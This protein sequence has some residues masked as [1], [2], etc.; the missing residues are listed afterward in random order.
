MDEKFWQ[1]I[2]GEFEVSTEKYEEDPYLLEE[3]THDLS[4]SMVDILEWA[5]KAGYK[6]AKGK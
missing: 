2:L 6:A 5:F 3:Q 1:W 4:G